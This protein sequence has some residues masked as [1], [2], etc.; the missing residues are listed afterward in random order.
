MDGLQGLQNG[1]VHNFGDLS[2]DQMN[3]RLIV[4]GKD[5]VAVDTVEALLAGW[6]PESVNYL[7]Y[8]DQAR[9]GNDDIARIRV[10]GKRVDEVRKYLDGMNPIAG[11]RK[12]FD[13]DAPEFSVKGVSNNGGRLEIIL[14]AERKIRKIEVYVDGYLL[15]PAVVSNFADIAYT[16]DFEDGET[17]EIRICAYDR[18]LNYSEQ[19]V[20]LK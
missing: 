12:I 17:H 16:N 19:T 4:A 13:R 2:N 6:D 5:P 1:P 18:F 14:D 8:L 7:K 11:G 15:E 20:E 3:M 10:A 9:A